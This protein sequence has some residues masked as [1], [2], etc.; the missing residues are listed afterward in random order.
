METKWWTSYPTLCLSGGCLRDWFLSHLTQNTDGTSARVWELLKAEVSRQHIRIPVPQADTRGSKMWEEAWEVLEPPAGLISEKLF[1]PAQ[2]IFFK[3]P[4]P[5]KRS[6]GI[7]RNRL[8]WPN[9]RNKIKLQK[10][11]L[12]NQIHDIPD[13]EF[14]V[15]MFNELKESNRQTMKQNQETMNE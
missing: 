6:Q 14:K 13:K 1:F 5:N 7:E 12:K 3:F 11:T 9:E 8:A 10:L 2:R 4:N 15:K